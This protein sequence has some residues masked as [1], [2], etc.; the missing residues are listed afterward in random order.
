MIIT[1]REGDFEFAYTFKKFFN[2]KVWSIERRSRKRKLTIQI[3]TITDKRSMTVRE[4]KKANK[5][6]I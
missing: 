6:E 5:P 3:A 1:R 2:C 4:K